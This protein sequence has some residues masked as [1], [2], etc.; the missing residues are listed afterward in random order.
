MSSLSSYPDELDNI[1]AGKANGTPVRDDHPE[2]HDA[3]ANAVNAVQQTLGTNPEGDAETVADRLAELNAAAG[4]GKMTYNAVTGQY[5]PTSQNT[6][7]QPKE[8]IGPVDP[9]TLPGVV[10]NNYDTW[11]STPT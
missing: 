4:G 3:L 9:Q 8:F 6:S 5:E 2:H 7:S 11:L 1:E 10:I